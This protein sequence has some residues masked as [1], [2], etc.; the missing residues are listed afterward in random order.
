M[1]KSAYPGYVQEKSGDETGG[2][3]ETPDEKE[4]RHRKQRLDHERRWL[5]QQ[6][7][8]HTKHAAALQSCEVLTPESRNGEYLDELRFPVCALCLMQFQSRYGL[9]KHIE[10][11]HGMACTL[12]PPEIR[13]VYPDC[14]MLGDHFKLHS[15]AERA[16]LETWAHPCGVGGCKKV[17]HTKEI[18]N[19]HR[20]LRGT[21]GQCQ[22]LEVCEECSSRF[23]DKKNLK[24]HMLRIHKIGPNRPHGCQ[25]CLKARYRN[26]IWL[27]KHMMKNHRHCAF[28]R[29]WFEKPESMEQHNAQMHKACPSC[30]EYLRDLP[31]LYSHL[32]LKHPDQ[33]VALMNQQQVPGRPSPQ[34]N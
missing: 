8:N 15:L 23:P 34:L 27:E 32:C 29:Q 18:L 3:L 28:C 25:F 24:L 17:F 21:S 11:L 26:R 9:R 22:K 4:G 20:R 14:D 7:F 16:K 13:T 1:F 6:L 30:P 12:C 19:Q 2:D 10:K 31:G 33:Y 5:D